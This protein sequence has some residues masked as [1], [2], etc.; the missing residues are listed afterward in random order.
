V[1]SVDICTFPKSAISKIIYFYQILFMKN[2]L[3][4]YANIYEVKNINMF[5]F[6]QLAGYKFSTVIKRIYNE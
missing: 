6:V 4:V 2:V 5:T 1:H 3:I